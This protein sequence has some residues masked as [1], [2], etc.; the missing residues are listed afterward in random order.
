MGP[1]RLDPVGLDRHYN[2]YWLLP[3]AA[4]ATDPATVH[5]AAP[6]L[7]V[8]ERHAQDSLAPTG[9]AAAAV[10]VLGGPAP[11]VPVGGG[12]PSWQVG[13]YNSILQLQ[14][15]A[16]WLCPKGTRERPLADY[17]TRLLDQHQQ[18]AMAHAQIARGPAP[19]WQP[20][21]PAAARAA[22]VQRLQRAMLSFEEGN[23]VGGMCSWLWIGLVGGRLSAQRCR[24]GAPHAGM[25]MSL[26]CVTHAADGA[27]ASMRTAG[28]LMLLLC[29]RHTIPQAATYDEL[30]GSEERRHRWRQM[31]LASSTPRVSWRLCTGVL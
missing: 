18:F 23:Q 7:L 9:A 13:V 1:V 16:Q 11:N 29:T 15:L 5:P 12:A 10:A 20:L 22:A 2:R 30:I 27:S 3:A 31:V 25:G 6:P 8:I 14:Q 19:D 26:P 4:V 17:V 28:G 21:D 24:C